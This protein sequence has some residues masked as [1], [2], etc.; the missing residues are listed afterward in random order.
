LT[1]LHGGVGF[2]WAAGSK[3]LGISFGKF[4]YYL[5][6]S[7]H[8]N[9]KTLGSQFFGHETDLQAHV[10]VCVCVITWDVV[11]WDSDVNVILVYSKPILKCM[12]MFIVCFLFGFL[13]FSR[14]FFFWIW[15]KL[16]WNP[17]SNSGTICLLAL[18]KFMWPYLQSGYLFWIPFNFLMNFFWFSHVFVNISFAVL[19]I[20]NEFIM[21]F[22]WISCQFLLQVL[23]IS[24]TSNDFLM[25]F[26]W[27]S[28][29]ILMNS[30]CSSYAVWNFENNV[31][32][33]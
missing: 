16:H 8:C 30:L 32:T 4:R 10:C 2:T 24:M 33:A 22:L 28:Y 26:S 23:C 9:R 27:N 20:S 3:P 25:N 6:T 14:G 13:A 11:T 5:S 15:W 18:N 7:W 17:F 12:L 29:E 21:I 1:G 31:K 19:M